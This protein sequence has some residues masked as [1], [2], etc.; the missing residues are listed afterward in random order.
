[1]TKNIPVVKKGRKQEI[2]VRVEKSDLDE[3]LS[4]EEIGFLF[5]ELSDEIYSKKNL[6]ERLAMLTPSEAKKVYN[7][8]RHLRK[9]ADLLGENKEQDEDEDWDMEND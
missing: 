5:E 6:A 8:S 2:P 9:F 1:M 3:E 7:A 4:D